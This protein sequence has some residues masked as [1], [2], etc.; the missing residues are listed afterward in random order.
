VPKVGKATA[1]F[2]SSFLEVYN[3]YN[4]SKQK[5]NVRSFRDME[6]I[7]NYV[8]VCF[9]SEPEENLHALLLDKDMHL[10]RD[11]IISHG[12][13]SQVPLNMR[14]LT[15]HCLN[16]KASYV[17]LCH[18]HPS[19]ILFPSSHDVH[20]TAEVATVLHRLNIELLDHIIVGTDGVLS[21]KNSN[22]YAY[23]FF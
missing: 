15:M 17:V 10:I 9:V 1:L 12:I 16:S 23:L 18:N 8:R 20:L 2:L 5:Q 14:S 21:M 19:N 11:E 3:R 13:F 7:S 22:E 6:D 4:Q